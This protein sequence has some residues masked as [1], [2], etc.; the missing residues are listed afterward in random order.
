MLESSAESSFQS[1]VGKVELL[2]AIVLYLCVPLVPRW[3]DP[4]DY[5]P[6]IGYSS[7]A[8]SARNTSAVA[9]LFGE[10]RTSMSD[11]MFVKTERYL[12]NGIGYAPHITEKDLSDPDAVQTNYNGTPTLIRPPTE[13]WRGFIGD[14]EREIKPWLDPKTHM[15]H[16]R[17]MEL[18][19]WFR[20]MTLVN[21]H[22]IRGYRIGAF[23]MMSRESVDSLQEALDY[24]EEGLKNN[25]DSHELLHVKIRLI[26]QDLALQRAHGSPAYPET[27]KKYLEGAL[28]IARKGIE[29]GA[30]HRPE[31]GWEGKGRPAE[32]EDSFLGLLHY[33]VF[34]L[35]RLG[36]N[37][38][39]LR[40]AVKSME[41]FGS[42]PVLQHEVA[43]LRSS[44]SS[45]DPDS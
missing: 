15:S 3:F 42:D 11:I 1:V 30:T 34:L 18:L 13:D 45:Q 7:E 8:Q 27:E 19:P 23:L 17:G 26:Q 22:R 25:P 12:H 36:R 32:M 6:L 39:A 14:I 4:N 29:V 37:E 44:L 40:C 38:E 9:R 24:I 5:T 2:L 28:K 41:R 35:R 20:L 33:E 31:M 43:E 10:L 16:E 21:P